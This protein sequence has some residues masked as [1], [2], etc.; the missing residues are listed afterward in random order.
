VL[1]GL[2]NYYQVRAEYQTA[3]ALGEQLL[4]L[5]QQVQDS[6]MLMAAHRALGSTLFLLGA[7]ASAQ[8]HFAQGIALYD[9]T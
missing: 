6:A 9:P 8:P 3:H 2:W 5:A 4:T 7:A 1:R